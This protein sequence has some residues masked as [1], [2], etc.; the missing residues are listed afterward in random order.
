MLYAILKG[1]GT[2]WRATTT[3]NLTVTGLMTWHTARDIIQ[4]ATSKLSPATSVA[5]WKNS[6][7]AVRP[8][9]EAGG[10]QDKHY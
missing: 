10:T 8:V 2:M 4:H 7:T 3:P 6:G 5:G 1:V 9:T